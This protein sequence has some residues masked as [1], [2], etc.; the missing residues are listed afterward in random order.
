MPLSHTM[1]IST[2][3]VST[4]VAVSL[5]G[6]GPFCLKDGECFS[7]GTMVLRQYHQSLYINPFSPKPQ[8]DYIVFNNTAELFEMIGYYSCHEAERAAIAENGY[9][10]MWDCLF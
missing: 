9:R 1:S 8:R 7:L 2:Y 4:K 6:N 3:I 10:Y 5:N